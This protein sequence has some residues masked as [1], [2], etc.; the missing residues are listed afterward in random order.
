MVTP[1]PTIIQPLTPELLESTITMLEE[2]FPWPEC[3]PSPALRA[4]F[5]PHIH[6][7]DLRNNGIFNRVQWVATV[8]GEVAGTVGLYRKL[9]DHDQFIYLGWFCVS[10]NFRQKGLGRSLLRYAINE[11]SKTQ[12]KALRLDTSD[13]EDEKFAVSL[14]KSEGFNIYQQKH[15]QYEGKDWNEILMEKHLLSI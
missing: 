2:I 14:Y 3:E 10:K 4:I 13:W 6:T 5:A 15:G 1:L 11:A 8:S 7:E 12:A 9:S